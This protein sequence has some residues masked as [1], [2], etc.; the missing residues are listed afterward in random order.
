[1]LRASLA[2]RLASAAL[3]ASV[4]AGCAEGQAGGAQPL[5]SS[6]SPV[7][8]GTDSRRE[9]FEPA[10]EAL[11]RLARSSNLAV[12]RRSSLD[13]TDPASVRVAAPSLGEARGLCEDARF[14]DQPSAA[15]CSGVLI[16]EDLL[17]LA[18][19]CI[20][21]EFSCQD[22]LFVSGYYYDAPGALH[23]IR[24]E[25]VFACRRLAYWQPG[26][27]RG[28]G[29]L[30]AAVVQLDRP[31]QAPL[32]P[33]ALAAGAPPPDAPVTAI[34][35]GEGLPG[36][37]DVEGRWLESSAPDGGRAEAQVDAFTGS[38]GGGVFD[39]LHELAGIVVSG[40]RDYA[41]SEEGCVTVHVEPEAAAKGE[42]VVLAGRAVQAL[43]E[44]GW[45]SERLCG[46]AGVCGDSICALGEELATCAAD[47]PAAACG[48][49]RCEADEWRTCSL[50]CGPTPP[51]HWVCSSL[52][53]AEGAHCD[54]GCG[55]PDPDCRAG[56]CGAPEGS[57]PGED[58]TP[59]DRAR[60]RGG[61]SVAGAPRRS[62][63]HVL[64]GVALLALLLRVR[65]WE[66]PGDRAGR[67]G[68]HP[69]DGHRAARSS[70]R[71]AANDSWPT[72]SS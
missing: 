62:A 30:D 69:V 34:G 16:D 14:V 8:Y 32:L 39:A 35:Y 37:L 54:C 21:G 33:A 49:G 51:G 5:D 70:R 9:F 68:R 65:R 36:K 23:P 22:L 60:D 27:E 44:E 12:F 48:D 50:D 66:R 10:S 4:E 72:P 71:G 28:E 63:G 56:E 38:S 61:C 24:Q 15:V 17:L 40:R 3:L 42:G 19:H 53:Y 46:D 7:V 11:R 31:V 41:L 59:G 43:C 57:A 25:D 64:T 55:A 6:S 47:C 45:P 26:R 1:M 18:G 29:A 67:G 2:I 13:G 52:W 20:E 58:V